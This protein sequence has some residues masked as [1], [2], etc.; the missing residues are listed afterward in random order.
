MKILSVTSVQSWL[1]LEVYSFLGMYVVLTYDKLQ[2]LLEEGADY[3]Y[4]EK[5]REQSNLQ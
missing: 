2:F 1:K 3:P 4:L 5:K